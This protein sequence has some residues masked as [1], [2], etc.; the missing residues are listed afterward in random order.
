MISVKT[1]KILG[2]DYLKKIR[3]K[4]ELKNCDCNKCLSCDDKILI[5]KEFQEKGFD[6]FNSKV[7]CWKTNRNELNNFE[8]TPY[9]D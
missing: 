5:L 2:R 9:E 6:T 1:Q 7:Y 8:M 3:S 4:E